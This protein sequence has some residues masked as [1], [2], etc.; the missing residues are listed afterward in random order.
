V[1]DRGAPATAGRATAW[2][3]DELAAIRASGLER[4]VLD[5]AGAPGPT[6]V[7]DGRE[8]LLL[9]SNNYLDLAAHPLVVEGAM[10]AAR[11]FGAGSGASRLVSG[12]TQLHA[13]LEAR[14][15]GFVGA[16]AVLL[17]SSGYLANVSTIQAL[18]GEGDV[19]FSDALNHASIIDGCR[20]S[21]ARVEVYPHG[22]LAALE[23]LLERTPGR[24]R[25]LVSDTVFSMEGDEADVA[26]LAAMAERFDAMLMLDESHALGVLGPDGAG[27]VVEQGAAGSVDVRM[28]TLSKALGSAGGFIAGSAAL[29]HLLRHR[30]RGFVFDT[31][32]APPSVGAALAALD[33][34][35]AEPERRHRLLDLSARLRAGLEGAGLKPQPGRSAIVPLVIGDADAAMAVAARMREAGVLAPAIRPPSVPPGT[36]RLRLTVSA[37]FT[38]AQVDDAVGA[39]VAATT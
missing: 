32:P 22:D 25:L 18:V 9:G 7:L 35:A 37:G 30:A 23:R 15:A 39:I 21:H 2:I 28:G 17:F 14:L 38:P 26:A 4:R 31:A 29:V 24:R 13:D 36:S 20:L 11:G 34:I 19:V 3:D 33:V 12:A 16:E 10:A 5:L 1:S 8:M 27:L 6:V